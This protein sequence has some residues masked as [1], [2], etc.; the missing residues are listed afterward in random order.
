MNGSSRPRPVIR[1]SGGGGVLAALIF[2][3]VVLLNV[4]WIGTLIWAIIKLVNHFA[5]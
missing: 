4:A 5:S 3:V 2:L 1:A